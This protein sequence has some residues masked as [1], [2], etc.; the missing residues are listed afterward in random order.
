MLNDAGCDGEVMDDVGEDVEPSPVG[1][2]A[3]IFLALAKPVASTVAA[4]AKLAGV[5]APLTNEADTPL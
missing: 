3:V 2:T 1:S 4:D 5:N